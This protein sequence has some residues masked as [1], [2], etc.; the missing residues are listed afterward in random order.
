MTATLSATFH[1]G[2]SV[3]VLS[4]DLDRRSAPALRDLLHARI[5]LGQDFVLDLR[6]I[7][8]FGVAALAELLRAANSAAQHDVNWTMVTWGSVVDRTID[9][10][11]TR[12]VLETRPDLAG[13]LANLRGRRHHPG[14]I[15][16]HVPTRP[17]RTDKPD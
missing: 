4:G 14:T 10:T 17:F 5:T 2:E 15:P 1:S 6:S 7:S 3:L 11:G 13:A 16:A 8:F 12:T 9:A